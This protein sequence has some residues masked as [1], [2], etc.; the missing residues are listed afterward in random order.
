[1]IW[2]FLGGW[3]GICPQHN[4]HN[5]KAT[6]GRTMLTKCDSKRPHSSECNKALSR[7]QC[8]F[9]ERDFQYVCSSNR[10]MLHVSITPLSP[11]GGW[12]RIFQRYEVLKSCK[13]RLCPFFRRPVFAQIGRFVPF[14]SL[15]HSILSQRFLLSQHTLNRLQCLPKIH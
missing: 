9:S 11:R 4:D 12:K 15:F 8:Q 14:K 13:W 10:H 7:P 1:M 6:S 2:V 5:G 3:V